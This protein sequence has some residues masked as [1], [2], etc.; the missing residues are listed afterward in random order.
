MEE[1]GEDRDD[2]RVC[3][4]SG[5]STVTGGEL[6]LCRLWVGFES[7]MGVEGG[8]K[9]NERAKERGRAAAVKK[10]IWPRAP[11][12]AQPISIARFSR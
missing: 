1:Y 7:S 3:Q 4:T 5:E 2:R 10:T 9:Q 8:G 6:R 11:R 12:P